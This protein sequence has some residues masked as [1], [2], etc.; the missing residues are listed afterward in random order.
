MLSGLFYCI[1]TI[2]VMVVI[3]DSCI[4]MMIEKILYWEVTNKFFY[5][6][7]SGLKGVVVG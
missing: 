2:R 3:I 5:L 7:L 4:C 6:L 1:A